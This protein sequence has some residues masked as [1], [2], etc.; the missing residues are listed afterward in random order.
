MTTHHARYSYSASKRSFFTLIIVLYYHV[1]NEICQILDIQHCKTHPF[2][3]NLQKNS[4]SIYIYIY[5][6]YHIIIWKTEAGYQN[7]ICQDKIKTRPP[8]PWDNPLFTEFVSL[9]V[10][11]PCYIY[12]VICWYDILELFTER[13]IYQNF[14]LFLI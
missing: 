7:I 12:A 8:K 6:T 3:L 11:V 1:D 13:N 10:N 2:V 9:V 14:K 5:K 4:S